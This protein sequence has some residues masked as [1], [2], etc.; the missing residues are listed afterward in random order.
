MKENVGRLDRIIRGVVGPSAVALSISQLRKH[1]I[2]AALGIV[3]GAIVTETAVTRVCPVSSALGIDTRSTEER[4][5][6]FRTE[7][8][9]ESDRIT[10]TYDQPIPIDESTHS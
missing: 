3:V 7:I 5:R 2:L 8:D 4:M 1:P 10:A 9:E 6:D